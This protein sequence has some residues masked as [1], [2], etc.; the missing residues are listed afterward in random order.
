MWAPSGTP[1]SFGADCE[2]YYTVE[3]AKGDSAGV[4]PIEPALLTRL[5]ELI[6]LEGLNPTDYLWYGRPGGAF[7]R[8]HHRPLSDAGMQKFWV[9]IMA[10]SG[11]PYRNLHVTRHTYATNWRRRGLSLDDVGFALRHADFKTTKQVYDHTNIVDIRRR[12]DQ[13]PSLAEVLS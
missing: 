12:M 7:K 6:T 4:A 5:D 10:E 9:R 8:Q 11:I 2:A 1:A 13:L 3:G